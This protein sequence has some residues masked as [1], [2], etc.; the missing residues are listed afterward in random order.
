MLGLARASHENKEMVRYREERVL[1]RARIPVKHPCPFNTFFIAAARFCRAKQ[2]RRGELTSNKRI[3]RMPPGYICKAEKSARR[4][5]RAP[6]PRNMAK[7]LRRKSSSSHM[8]ITPPKKAST[9]GR[10]VRRQ[11]SAAA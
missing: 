7:R 2:Q 9:A 6:K 8:T 1:A 10:T 5:K 4:A 3:I 11:S